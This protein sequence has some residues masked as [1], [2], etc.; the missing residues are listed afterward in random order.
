MEFS[1][2]VHGLEE[3]EKLL[4]Q[5]PDKPARAAL[6]SGLRAGGKVI[7]KDAIDRAPVLK[8]PPRIVTY[9]GKKR[10]IVPGLLK[11]AIIVTKRKEGG[12]AVNFAIAV[13]KIAFYAH[14]VEWG[15]KKMRAMP[16]MRPALDA[17]GEEAIKVMRDTTLRRILK[18]AEKLAS[19]YGTNRRKRR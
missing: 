4:K 10:I 9:R 17:K 5:L 18:E 1:A 11:K 3:I 8:G 14:W 2:K 19:L 15:T 12:G 7:Q 16:F 13:T 6:E